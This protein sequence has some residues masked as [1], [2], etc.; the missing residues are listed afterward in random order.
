MPALLTMLL[1]PAVLASI[2]VAALAGWLAGYVAADLA[3]SERCEAGRLRDRMQVMV[4]QQETITLAAEADEKR[5]RITIQSDD[6]NG[7]A[8]DE[9]P[10]NPA[11]CLDADAAR[12]VRAIR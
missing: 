2:G 12:R 11:A 5:A 6:R 10:V 7:R 4:L 8:V 1:N 3:A 9:T